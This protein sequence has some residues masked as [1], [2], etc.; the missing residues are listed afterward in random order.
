VASYLLGGEVQ[1][2]SVKKA[3]VWW[4]SSRERDGAEQTVLRAVVSPDLL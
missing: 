4:L 1:D 2:W 3:G